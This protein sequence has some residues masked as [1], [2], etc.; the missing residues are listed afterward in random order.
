MLGTALAVTLAATKTPKLQTVK[1]TGEI[2]N[3]FKWP[4]TDEQF[5]LT[6]TEGAITVLAEGTLYTPEQNQGGV[7]YP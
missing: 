1:V 7:K 3:E 5:R 2:V 6:H 4:N